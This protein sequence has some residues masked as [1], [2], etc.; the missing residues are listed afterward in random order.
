MKTKIFSFQRNCP[1]FL[2]KDLSNVSFEGLVQW[3]NS[4]SHE[5]LAWPKPKPFLFCGKNLI[6]QCRYQHFTLY[7]PLLV[8]SFKR[9]ITTWLSL[10]N[11]QQ[12]AH[13]TWQYNISYRWSIACEACLS[14]FTSDDF[15]TKKN[16]MDL[17][18][19]HHDGGTL[20]MLM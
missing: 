20:E 5:V 16:N 8:K 4:R 14:G 17:S 1:M 12:R 9:E 7:I 10:N 11:G 3:E 15:C 6:W 19:V 2:L 18:H 13:V